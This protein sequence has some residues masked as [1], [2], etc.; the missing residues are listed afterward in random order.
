[1]GI[2]P[3]DLPANMREAILRMR[4]EPSGRR[5]ARRVAAGAWRAFEELCRLSV[6]RHVELLTMPPCG[7]KWVGKRLVPQRIA[8]D[9]AGTVRAT[10]RAFMSDAKS[11][12][13]ATR[14]PVG[15]R[16]FVD[17]DLRREVI[18]QGRAGAIAG[19]FVERRSAHEVYWVPWEVLAGGAASIPWNPV[20]GVLALGSTLS[21]FDVAPVL[22]RG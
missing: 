9:I 2:P 20:A 19:L 11:T 21:T 7:A 14:C 8:C 18:A 6:S 22:R 1:M 12:A 10:G 13:L 17:D 16:E 3:R 4:D 5:S 15:N